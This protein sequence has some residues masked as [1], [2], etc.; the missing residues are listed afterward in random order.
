MRY[1]LAVAAVGACTLL[2]WPLQPLLGSSNSFTLYYPVIILVSWIAGLGPGIATVLLSAAAADYFFIEPAGSM[3]I[4]SPQVAFNLLLFLAVSAVLSWITAGWRQAEW[5]RQ[6]AGVHQSL[7]QQRDREEQQAMARI[8]RILAGELQLERLAQ[9]LI[10]EAAAVLGAGLGSFYTAG[11]ARGVP[12]AAARSGEGDEGAGDGGEYTLLTASGAASEAFGI[13]GG[14]RGVG[15]TPGV[16]AAVPAPKGFCLEI[17]PGAAELIRSDDVRVDPRFVHGGEHA[18]VAEGP[19]VRSYLAAP[20]VARSGQLLGCLAFAHG[21]PERFGE[22]EERILSGIAVQAAVALDNAHLYRDAQEARATAEGASRSKDEFLATVSHEL[23]T[24]LNAMMAWAQVI[25]LNRGDE[26]KIGAGLEVIVRNGEAQA[27]LIDDLLDISR[28]VSGKMR[29]GIR[30]ADLAEI[31]SAAMAAVRPA[32]LAKSIRMVSHLDAAKMPLA[33]DPDRLQQVVWNLL[34]NAVKFTPR[35]GT[36]DVR[37]ERVDAYAEV[38]VSDTGVGVSADFL[39]HMFER[40]RR[41]DSLTTVPP[42]GLGLGLAIVRHLVE[43]HGGTVKVES[44]GAGRGSTFSVRLPLAAAAG[45]R[46]AVEAEGRARTA[47]G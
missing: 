14:A 10:D 21:E 19:P 41:S 43:L 1:G 27:R 3:H 8:G 7:Q 26:Q 35:Q 36:V 5:R 9:A 16:P 22:R 37:L 29:L 40:F 44:P 42:G 25:Q 31:I 45:P 6:V 38:M 18:P 32:A 23:R 12:R 4:A 17:A 33:G 30:E 28:I 24:P 13:S 20:V 15:G 46:E 47:G 34:S 2:R 39:P 11:D